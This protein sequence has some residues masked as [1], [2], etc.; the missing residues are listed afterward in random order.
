MRKREEDAYKKLIELEKLYA[1][2]DQKL[3]LT[4]NEYTELKSRNDL[5]EKDL[6]ESNKEIINSKREI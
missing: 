4:E 1:L 3:E 5:K 6:R 2:V